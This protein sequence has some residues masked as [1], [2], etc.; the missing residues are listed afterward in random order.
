MTD[1]DKRVCRYLDRYPVSDFIDQE[2]PQ[3]QNYNPN[4][5][6]LKGNNDSEHQENIYFQLDPKNIS[7]IAMKYITNGETE[8]D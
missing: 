5:Y 4:I 1:T 2:D 3:F 8:L 7:E 6:K